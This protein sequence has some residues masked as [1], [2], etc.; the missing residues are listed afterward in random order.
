MATNELYT[1]KLHTII[2]TNSCIYIETTNITLALFFDHQFM[3]YLDCSARLSSCPRSRM[4]TEICLRVK[5]SRF[6]IDVGS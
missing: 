5:A 1:L 2:F 6:A 4:G 3:E